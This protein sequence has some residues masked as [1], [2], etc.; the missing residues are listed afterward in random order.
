MLFYDFP[1]LSHPGPYVDLVTVV[2]YL[3]EGLHGPWAETI[4]KPQDSVINVEKYLHGRMW[5]LLSLAELG[6]RGCDYI[7]TPAP[8]TVQISTGSCL[9]TEIHPHIRQLLFRQGSFHRLEIS[10]HQQLSVHAYQGAPHQTGFLQHQGH[11]F[12]VGEL[13]IRQSQF[14]QAGAPAGEHRGYPSALSQLQQFRFR[15]GFFKVVPFFQ[16]DTVL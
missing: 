13:F 7:V 8:N 3:L 14:F 11:H 4:V 12:R 5:A 6:T 9:L 10:A 2:F 1:A 15:E 16:L